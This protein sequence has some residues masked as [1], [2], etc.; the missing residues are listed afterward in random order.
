MSNEVICFLWFFETLKQKAKRRRFL[1]VDLLLMHL[2]FRLLLR[3]GYK[4]FCQLFSNF[5]ILADQ[6]DS[7]LRLRP[8][9]EL[10]Q[11]ACKLCPYKTLQLNV[12][13]LFMKNMILQ[14]NCTKIRILSSFF[15]KN[16]QCQN[17]IKVN[18]KSRK[19]FIISIQIST[20]QSINAT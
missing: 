17:E 7:M 10:N 6:S 15:M 13:L 11:I 9:T 1:D 16:F 14:S 19:L 18:C 3:H 12:S 8:Q 20:N 4:R 2:F 5:P